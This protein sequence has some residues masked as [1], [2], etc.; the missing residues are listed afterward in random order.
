[1]KREIIGT[2]VEARQ[3]VYELKDLASQLDLLAPA[4]NTPA[5]RLLCDSVREDLNH[6]LDLLRE[7]EVEPYNQK[8]S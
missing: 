5:V 1:M 2:I 6:V 7:C 4:K 3:K 8:D